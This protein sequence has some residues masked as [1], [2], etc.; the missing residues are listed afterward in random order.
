MKFSTGEKAVVVSDRDHYWPVLTIQVSE[1]GKENWYRPTPTYMFKFEGVTYCTSTNKRFGN[2]SA[3]VL[4][5]A[6]DFCLQ[7]YPSEFLFVLFIVYHE[8]L[9]GCI[10]RGRQII[11][12]LVFSGAHPVSLFHPSCSQVRKQRAFSQNTGACVCPTLHWNVFVCVREMKL[13][14]WPVCDCMRGSWHTEWEINHTAVCVC[15]SD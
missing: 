3:E 6:G 9:A 4:F 12:A 14:V 15:L 8:P 11:R 1:P 7:K 2:N 13:S 5:R 10:M